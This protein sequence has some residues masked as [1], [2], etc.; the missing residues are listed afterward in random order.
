MAHVSL[1]LNDVLCF[2]V[3]KFGKLAVKSLK[4]T[5][6]DFYSVDASSWGE[7]SVDKRCRLDEIVVEAS[8]YS[9]A[10]RHEARL[11]REVDDIISLF[12]FVDENKAMNLLPKYVSSSPDNM[13]KPTV[14]WWWPQRNF[15]IV[16]LCI[17][18]YFR[19]KVAPFFETQYC[20]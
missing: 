15:V 11:A 7:D 19:H 1:V 14:V 12:T 13:P 8:V 20:V 17:W 3:N 9:A 10:T 5:L 6:T 18:R 2:L 4:V 16:G